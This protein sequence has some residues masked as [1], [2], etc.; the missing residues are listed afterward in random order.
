MKKGFSLAEMLVVLVIVGVIITLTINTVKQTSEK[1][2]KTLYKAA[3]NNVETVVNELINDTALY[4]GAEFTD[5]TFCD[6]FFDKVNYIGAYSCAAP[7]V[8]AASGDTNTPSGSTSN[9]M[10]WYFMQDAFAAANCYT[11]APAGAE[12]IHIYVDVNGGKGKNVNTDPTSDTVDILSIYIFKTGKVAV[13]PGT[14]EADY[15]TQ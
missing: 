4:P 9:G 10:R 8:P 2:I 11:G 1:S 13:E 15:L 12:C 5:G 3:Y 14:P 6:N 7:S